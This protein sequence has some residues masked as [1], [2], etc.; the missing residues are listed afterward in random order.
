MELEGLVVKQHVYPIQATLRNDN[1]SKV[2]NYMLSA[3][4]V[5]DIDGAK[6][7]RLSKT[8]TAVRRL[9]TLQAC[10]G[11]AKTAHASNAFAMI[12]ASDVL[13]RLR[14]ARGSMVMEL[15]G[16]PA[17]KRYANRQHTW[18]HQ[19][20]FTSAVR[21]LPSATGLP[22]P[23]VADGVQSVT[24]RV[25]GQLVGNCVME[26]TTANLQWVMSAI[27]AQ[28][29]S[30][31]ASGRAYLK[32]RNDDANH[33]FARL[34]TSRKMAKCAEL[35]RALSDAQKALDSDSGSGDGDGDACE[36]SEPGAD[37]DTSDDEAGESIVY[38]SFR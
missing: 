8:D 36:S 20:R 15:C 25:V 30:G 35:A 23:F 18:M 31:D 37:A 1:V 13:E 19:K 21:K 22:T 38:R 2:H 16:V 9:L 14:H 33:E 32:R 4:H 24:M 7:L 34:R 29:S 10:A 5:V 26:L 27:A 17:S 28:Q 11:S 3:D 6:F 12:P